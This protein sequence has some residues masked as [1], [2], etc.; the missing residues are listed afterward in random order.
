MTNKRKSTDKLRDLSDE[1]DD[2]ILGA[3][4]AEVSEEL[5]SLGIDPEKVAAEMGATI[6][7]VVEPKC[8]RTPP[9]TSR[10]ARTTI[11]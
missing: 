7:A 2:S 8:C 5:A 6:N 9:R 10:S 11:R 3:S 4:D 1:I